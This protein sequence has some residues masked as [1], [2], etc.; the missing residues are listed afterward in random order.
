MLELAQT[1]S[2]E[3][4]I[5]PAAGTARTEGPVVSVGSGGAPEAEAVL[6]P[7]I[8]R[9]VILRRL[10]EGGMGIVYAAYDAELD[11]KVA[12][13]VVRS[14][15]GDQSQGRVR[16][17]REAQ[18]MA[19]V[20]HPN[21]V[22]V[23]EVGETERSSE[24]PRDSAR[25]TGAGNGVFIAME[26]VAGSTLY[27]WQL[28]PGRS[29]QEILAMYLQAGAGLLAAHRCGL[30]HRDFKP[31]AGIIWRSDGGA[32]AWC[33]SERLSK[34]SVRRRGTG[35]GMRSRGLRAWSDAWGE[36][37]PASSSS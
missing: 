9:Y 6:P 35:V 10:G 16:V 7:R 8:G 26:F 11:R 18:A 32:P 1:Q 4:G 36:P 34:G 5:P 37:L 14:Q 27:K 15:L 12:L 28:Q 25:T 2:S 19:Q 31:D 3:P 23:Y 29:A 30:I 24:G 22:H 21:V 13:K 20:S 17:L 33:V